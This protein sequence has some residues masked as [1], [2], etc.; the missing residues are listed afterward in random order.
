VEVPLQFKQ[1]AAAA[2]LCTGFAAQAQIAL[3]QGFDNVAGLAGAG[4]TFL[5]ASPSPG[6]NWFQGNTGIF[7]AA[8]GPANSYAAANFLGTTAT[9]GAVTNWLI[10]PQ[11]LLDPTSIVSLQVRGAGEG[12]LDR[13][14][15][16]VSTTG[17][18]PADFSVIGTY[19]TTVDE[20]W[21]ARN[22]GAG[23]MSATPAY[24]AFRYSVADVATAGNYLGIDNL[25]ITAV[26]E[27]TTTLLIGLGLAGLLARRRFSA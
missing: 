15:V 17:T 16:L 14:D 20:G 7:S 13:L 12:F 19:S 27:P 9:T 26:P 1:L 25:T 10:T 2:V 4:W 8:S 11:L 23:L 3:T 18:A 6:T 24:V 21:V 22:F 5:N